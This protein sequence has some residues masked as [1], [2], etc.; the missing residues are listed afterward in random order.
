MFHT[1]Y[2]FWTLDYFWIIFYFIVMALQRK[3]KRSQMYIDFVCN[4]LQMR[5][6]VKSHSI[7]YE[8]KIA[9]DDSCIFGFHPHGVLCTCVTFFMNYPHSPFEYAVGLSS[10]AMLIVPFTGMM[11][12]LWGI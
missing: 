1:M 5:K 9:N 7:I 12:R 6:G 2:I 3:V 4:V 10:R 11:L 8:E